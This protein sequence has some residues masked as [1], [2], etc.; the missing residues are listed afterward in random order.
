MAPTIVMASKHRDRASD[1]DR[2]SRIRLDDDY[3]ICVAHLVSIDRADARAE[4][5]RAS[6]GRPNRP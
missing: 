2:S 4:P 1:M 6:S 3:P 5:R